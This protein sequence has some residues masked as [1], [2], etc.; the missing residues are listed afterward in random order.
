MSYFEENLPSEAP[1]YID[2]SMRRQ[3][4]AS[5]RRVKAR[6]GLLEDAL[7]ITGMTGED[8]SFYAKKIFDT[9]V[10]TGGV[11]AFDK[12]TSDQLA[13]AVLLIQNPAFHAVPRIEWPNAEVIVDSAF[14]SNDEWA[15]VGR[16]LGVGGSDSSIIKGTNHFG[17]TKYA[18]YHNKRMTPQ[19]QPK[20]GKDSR[21]AIFDR[22]HLLEPKVIQAFCGMTGAVQ[23]P[24]TRMFR[25]KKFPHA[26]ANIDAIVRFPDGRIYVFEAKTTIAE[27]YDAWADNK[28][29][30]TYV[31]QTMQ[32]PAV[33]DDD[34]IAGT[35]IGCLFTYDYKVHGLYVG[36]DSDVG[37]FACR[38]V[39]RDKE[40]ENDLLSEE[41]SFFQDYI[42]KGVEPPVEESPTDNVAVLNSL[43]PPED[44]P[45]VV[46]PD[47]LLEEVQEWLDLAERKRALGKEIEGIKA[48]M[49]RASLPLIEALS[50]AERGVMINPD[51]PGI[52]YTVTNAC[53]SSTTVDKEMLEV[54]F[55]A[56]FAACV[57]RG[58]SDNP[59]FSVREKKAKKK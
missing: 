41:E 33:L 10:E 34:R 38:L 27:N 4:T 49:D 48:Q 28:V 9:K 59:T 25:S 52:E 6:M 40:A 18:L 14:M 17:G 8:F 45:G 22:G 23:I 21:Q 46:I 1:E 32:Y 53:R 58:K 5:L 11:E 57:S 35:Y 24:E 20:D 50:G 26:I 37:R 31:Y 51:I 15:S 36:S 2:A 54:A 29:P 7:D 3:V 43:Y 16:H 13:Q 56:A 19:K 42:L 55:P 44:I 30:Y 12:M 39:E 47:S